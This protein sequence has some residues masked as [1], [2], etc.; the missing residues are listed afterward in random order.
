MSKTSRI[1]SASGFEYEGLGLDPRAAPP[2][3]AGRSAWMRAAIVSFAPDP[4][5]SL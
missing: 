4:R 3:V 5:S 1:L 2:L